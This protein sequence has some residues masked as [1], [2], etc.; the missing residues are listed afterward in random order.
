MLTETTGSSIVP[1]VNDAFAL[2][3]VTYNFFATRFGR[4]SLDN[5][6]LPLK[7]TVKFCPPLS[8]GESCPYDNAFWNGVQMVYGQF[9]ASADDVVGH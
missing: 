7:S 3:G 1:D 2:S 9:Y 8:S 5:A 6:G 4:D